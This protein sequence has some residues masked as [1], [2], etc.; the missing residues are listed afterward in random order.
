MTGDE[1]GGRVVETGY[2]KINLYLHVGGVRTDGLHA[3]ESLFVFTEDG[4][5]IEARPHDALTLE[6]VGPFAGALAGEPPERN[7]VLRAARALRTATG[8]NDG[9]R[10]ILDKRLPVAAGIGGGSADAAAAL[11]ALVRLWRIDIDA[12]TLATLAFRLGADVPA[13]LSGAP[14]QVSG[15][16]EVLRPGPR[17]P[18]LWTVLINQGA[19]MPTGPVFR[20]FD[21]LHPAAAAPSQVGSVPP[22]VDGVRDLLACTHNAL[23]R[24]ALSLEPGISEAIACAANAPG[25]L[26]ARMSG[27]GASVFGLFS[28]AAAALRCAR[29]ARSRGWWASASPLRRAGST[30][31]A[32]A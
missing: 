32:Q 24:P 7:L 16:G 3:L 20:L 5:R 8:R 23:E 12:S 15:A 6:V 13:C 21:R 1:G 11:R 17:L 4:D 31:L 14:V 22:T 9:A 26:G 29:V 25:A 2:A 19:A 30:V 18:P 28:S 10:L 27:S